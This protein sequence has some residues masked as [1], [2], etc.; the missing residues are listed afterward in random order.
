MR[1]SAFLVFNRQGLVRMVKGMNKRH[2]NSKRQRPELRAGEYAVLVTVEVPDAVFE[3]R[4]TPEATITVSES[5][6]VTPAVH[7][8]T[9]QAPAADDGGEVAP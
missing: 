9:E 3:P 2:W 1:D 6:V 5:A 4:P 8:V 7:V